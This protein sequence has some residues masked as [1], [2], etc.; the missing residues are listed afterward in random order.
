MTAR[1]VVAGGERL[2]VSRTTLSNGIVVLGSENRTHPAVVIRLSVRAA[3]VLDTRERAGLASLTAA[4]LVRG[5]A[6]RSFQEINETIDAAG[7]SL[8]SGA[9]RHLSTVSARSLTEDLP[10]AI[11]LIGDVLRNPS[12]PDAEI[13][14]LRGQVLTGLRQADNDTGSVADR[15]FRELI[16]PEGHPYRL[17]THGY[18]ETV[19]AL[20]PA[21]LR[22]FHASSYGPAGAFVVV[23]GDVEFDRVV[24]ML[25]NTLGSWHGETVP[26]PPIAAPPPAPPQRRDAAV[27][28]KTQSDL[29]VGLPGLRRADPDYYAVRMANMIFGR[30]GMMGR[31]GDT[32]RE[33]Q[34]LAYGVHSELDASL[35]AGPWCVR[36]GVNPANVDTAL[37]SIGEQLDL[38]RERGVTDD[39]LL[40]G[41]RYST[42]SLVLQLETNDG[43]AGVIQ[44]IEFYGL[45]LDFIDRYPDIVNGL[46]R[47]A[48]SDAAR[49]RLPPYADTVKVVAGPEARGA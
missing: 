12:Y 31:L 24:E 48:V 18:Q 5:T 45:G 16:Y 38:L 43:V 27:P 1:D 22:D 40:R 9:G 30:L 49:R 8:S 26:A 25:E 20:T 17:R 41:Q 39:E 21:R 33:A 11:E 13:A 34:G 4:G 15:N 10:L 3:P 37:R 14:L 32:V 23:T 36:A 28:G 47:E 19:A 29:V 35:G 44:D 2:R 42:G 7:M 46:T 6:T